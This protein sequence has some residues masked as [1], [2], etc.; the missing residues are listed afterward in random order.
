MKLIVGGHHLWRD[1]ALIAD[2]LEKC[3]NSTEDKLR[4]VPASGR[5]GTLARQVAKQVGYTI[6]EPP[7]SKVLAMMPTTPPW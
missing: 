1:A 3:Q 5:C 6:I 4:I 7:Q 2:I